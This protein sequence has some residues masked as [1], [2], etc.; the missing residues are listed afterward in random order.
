[1][2]LNLFDTDLFK[3]LTVKNGIQTFVGNIGFDR[4]GVERDESC[5]VLYR[6]FMGINNTFVFPL[7]DCW[8]VTEPDYF[9]ALM[10]D[11]AQTLFVSPTKNDE[12]TVGDVILHG[13]DEM[14]SWFPDDDDKHD[15]ELLRKELEKVSL[16]VQVG[17]QTVIDT[18]G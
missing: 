17:G 6:N 10:Q 8:T 4:D 9:Q 13:I 16:F 7:C 14:I 18:R 5:L 12:H 11:A 1:M 2:G 3:P 15:K